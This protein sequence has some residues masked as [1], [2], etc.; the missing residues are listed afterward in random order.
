MMLESIAVAAI[1]CAAAWADSTSTLQPI[2]T[3]SRGM[4]SLVPPDTGRSLKEVS[5]LP[6]IAML[7][8]PVKSPIFSGWGWYTLGRV[9]SS[10]YDTSQMAYDFQFENEWLY[11]F[12]TGLKSCHRLETT[13]RRVCI[14][15][16]G[17]IIRFLINGKPTVMWSF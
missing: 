3:V 6:K 13:A 12:E 16:S 14:W 5:P 15:R 9:Q 17:S 4:Q 11:N 1:L 8:A 7:P 10:E 2:D